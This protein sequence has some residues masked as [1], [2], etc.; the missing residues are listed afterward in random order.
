MF[1]FISLMSFIVY[2]NAAFSNLVWQKEDVEVKLMWGDAQ[3][4]NTAQF[5][6]F[7]LTQGEKWRLPTAQEL[8]ETQNTDF[9]G[10]Y[11]SS[12]PIK[13]H[14]RQ[15]LAIASLR[16]QRVLAVKDIQE[17]LKVRCVREF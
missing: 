10:L 12:T 5:H 4:V 13:N 15:A 17:K 14:P 11:W 1:Y 8:I 9:S 3:V 16:D 6:C 2:A 7:Y